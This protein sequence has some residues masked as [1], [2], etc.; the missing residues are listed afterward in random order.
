MHIRLVTM[1]GVPYNV[2]KF[3]RVMLLQSHMGLSKEFDISVNDQ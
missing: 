3:G 2:A 1:A